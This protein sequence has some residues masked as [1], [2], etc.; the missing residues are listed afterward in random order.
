VTYRDASIAMLREKRKNP[1][2]KPYQDNANV[3]VL[4]HKV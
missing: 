3:L 4:S 2:L 1:L